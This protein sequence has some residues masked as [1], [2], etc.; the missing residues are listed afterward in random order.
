MKK[1]LAAL[2]AVVL[3]SGV[4]VT[5]VIIRKNAGE[6]NHKALE[7]AP[8]Q[9]SLTEEST[10]SDDFFVRGESVDWICDGNTPIVEPQ[11]STFVLKSI[12]PK[13]GEQIELNAPLRLGYSGEFHITV[14]HCEIFSTLEEAGVDWADVPF[15]EE[16]VKKRLDDPCFVLVDL[17]LE[18]VNAANRAAIQY[19]FSASM[20]D[21]MGQN[22]FVPPN[23]TNPDYNSLADESVYG[24]F[25]FSDHADGEKDYYSFMLEPG[26][27]LSVQLGFF[28]ERKFVEEQDLYLKLGAIRNNLCGIA[29]QPVTE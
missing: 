3:V 29:L 19:G 9:S 12:Q 26:K 2:L 17:T 13:Q 23:N 24:Q 15:Q 10:Y 21:L 28:V 18:N 14:N 20:F 22:D 8:S 11:G 25:Y 16:S 7:T 6:E 4:F 5:A 27:S 1:I